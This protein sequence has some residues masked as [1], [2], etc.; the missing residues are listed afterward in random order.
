MIGWV[1]QSHQVTLVAAAASGWILLRQ[2]ASI[3][4]AMMQRRFSFMRRVVVDPVG[5]VVF[6]AV[7]IATTASGMG[8][9]GLVL[10]TYAQFAAMALASWVLAR[11]RPNLRLASWAMW[12]ELIGFGRHVM[13]SGVI[14]MVSGSINTA[15]IGR[16]FGIATLGQLRYG[17][18]IV[19]APL[20]L[21]VN[22]GSYVL[23]GAV[24]GSPRTQR[25]SSGP[26]GARS[27]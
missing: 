26:F 19:A 24:R 17:N 27:G 3:P 22:A 14:G 25:D 6:G 15:I 8:V 23:P 12:R 7:A 11:W 4:D 20:G 5:I 18:R 16:V 10:G 13:A 2:V 21:M 1:F 9:W